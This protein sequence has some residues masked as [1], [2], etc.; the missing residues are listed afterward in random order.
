M[1]LFVFQSLKD[2]DYVVRDKI[3]FESIMDVEFEQVYDKGI[4]YN[5][6]LILPPIPSS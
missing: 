6:T 3:F 2:V 5:G 4:F 1:F